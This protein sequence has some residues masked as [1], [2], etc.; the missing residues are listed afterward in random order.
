[1]PDRMQ[2]SDIVNRLT[3]SQARLY[4][5]IMSILPDPDQAHDVLQNTNR[6]LWEKADAYDPKVPFMT[7][8][9][10]VARNQV[11]AYCRDKRRDRHILSEDVADLIADEVPFEHTNQRLNALH[12]CLKKLPPS[13]RA[14]VDQRYGPNGSV[15]QIARQSG[16]PAASISMSLG[17]IRKALAECIQRTLAEAEGS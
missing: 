15:A 6:V 17:R 10:G 12:Q 3:E 9:C 5:Y 7:W 1:M 2:Y 14:I 16:R 11:R 4:A 8:A 13:Q